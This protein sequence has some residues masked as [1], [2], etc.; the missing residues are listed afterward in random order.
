MP[1]CCHGPP[2]VVLRYYQIY[3]PFGVLSQFSVALEG[4]RGLGSLYPFPRDVYPLGRLDEDSEG[5]LLLTNDT[6]QNSVFLGQGVE[7]R[8]LVQVE[9]RVADGQLEPMRRGMNIR[10][11]GQLHGCLPVEV[12]V[13]LAPPALPERTPAV[14]FRKSVPD[15]W[16]MLTLREGKNRQVRRMTAALGFPTLRLVRW[17]IGAFTLEGMKPGEVRE[18]PAA[19]FTA[20]RRF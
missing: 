16:L 8:Y 15:S 19:L 2:I 20:T 5:L 6:L 17:S 18:M 9:G 13:L 1:G 10:I 3:K 14:R 4:K 7:K 12:E 11:K